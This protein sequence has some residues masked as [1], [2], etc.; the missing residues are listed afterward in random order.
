MKFEQNQELFKVSVSTSKMQ[1]W[2]AWTNEDQVNVCYGQLDGK[3]TTSSY[4]AEPKNIGKVNETTPSEQ[5]EVELQAL[6]QSQIDNKHYRLTK[7]AAIEL[8][9]T[10]KEPRK[11]TNYKDRFDKMSDTLLTSIKLNGSRACVLQG[12]LYSKVGRAEDV[13]VPHLKA[14][15]EELGEL[16]TFDAEVYGEGLSLQRIRSAWLKPVRTD[17]EVIKVAKDRIKSKGDTVTIKTVEEAV[18]YLGYNPNNDQ[19]KLKFHI[20]DIPDTTGK[21]YEGRAEDMLKFENLI[22]DKNLEVY[23]GFLYPVETDSHESRMNLLE[24]VCSEGNEGL[25]HYEKDGV[26]EFG[27]RSKNAAKSKPRYDSEALVTGVEKCKNG[28]GKLLLKACDALDGVEFK[29]MMK[30]TRSERDYEVQKGFIG[31]WVTFKYEELSDKGV[32]TK[33]VVEE[34]RLCDNEGNPLN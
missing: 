33:P 4:T 9:N 28:E 29:A 5:A 25:V 1:V 21:T 20:F 26:Y 23:F 3:M 32:P 24:R 6:Y 7:E 30:G 31:K 18:D 2:K 10:N 11:I 34:T 14:V 13:K 15:L 8:K 12:Q 22:E 16:A 19:F 17:K 27:K